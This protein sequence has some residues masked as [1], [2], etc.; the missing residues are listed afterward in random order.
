MQQKLATLQ[1]T[2]KLLLHTPA[3]NLPFVHLRQVKLMGIASQPFGP[4][5]RGIG[6]FQQYVEIQTISGIHRDSETSSEINFVAVQVE[7]IH[8]CGNYFLRYQARVLR[9]R[10][11]RK[12]K[13]ELVSSQ[14][15]D[16]VACAHAFQQP[17]RDQLEQLVTGTMSIGVVNSF[18]FIQIEKN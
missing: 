5:H 7:W 18:E 17:P 16:R 13:R 14:S 1:C 12:Y 4:I 2:P 15:G 9:F 10:K 8:K 3:L 11:I 6:V